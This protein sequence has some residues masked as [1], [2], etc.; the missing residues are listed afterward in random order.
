M[1]PLVSKV[2]T[3]SRRHALF[4]PGEAV[5]VGVSGGPDSLCLLHILRQL[6]SELSLHLIVAHLHHGLRGADADAD[7]RFV[8]ETA[9]AFGLPLVAGQADVPALARERRLSPEEA[10]R[11][12]RYAFLAD[13][14]ARTGAQTVAVGHHADDQAETVLMHLLRGSGVS[15]LRG[16]LPR[17]P[18]TDYRLPG[19][20]GLE[21]GWVVRPLLA[22][23]RAEIVAYCAA[24]GL[25]PR[26]D[27]SNEDATFFRN[28]LRHEL[29]PLLEEYNSNI[30]EVLVHTGEAMAGDAEVL[31][32][33]LDGVWSETVRRSAA[34]EVCFDLSRWRDLP[35]GLQRGTVREAIRRLRRD[36]RNV[37]WQHVERAVWLA[38][39]GRAGQSATLVGGLALD[40]GCETLRIAPEGSQRAVDTPQIE[41]EIALAAPGMTDVG[42]G[43][44]VAVERL[45]NAPEGQPAPGDP[46]QAWLDADATG[47]A[48]TLRPRRPG[49][50][51]RPHGLGGHSAG[52]NEFMINARVPRHART[53]WPLLTGREGI[54]WVCGLRVDH[55]AAV[56]PATHAIWRVRFERS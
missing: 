48:L 4:R 12:A 43:W 17:T 54:A 19:V 51:F 45:A 40:L 41:R 22:L 29:L 20:Q 11:Q 21:A 24:H 1:D 53:G 26:Y 33:Q 38:R 7:A 36:L 46:W 15:G 16:M 2:A 50:R 42:G 37:G 32:A 30:R 55:Q 49:D 6:A 8:A 34:G 25:T 52:L 9:L 44:R 47:P 35:I 5:V 10:A 28:R 31:R 27:M 39:G 14:A 18:L 23:W 13:T 3:F 56:T